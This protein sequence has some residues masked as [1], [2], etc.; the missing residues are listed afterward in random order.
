MQWAA[1][2][3]QAAE[4][5]GFTACKLELALMPAAITVLHRMLIGHEDNSLECFLF[6]MSVLMVP[7]ILGSWGY[8]FVIN[9][10]TI[11][12]LILDLV[13]LCRCYWRIQEYPIKATYL[14]HDDTLAHLEGIIEETATGN[15]LEDMLKNNDDPGL[16]A[17]SM[18]L[19]IPM[20]RDDGVEV[21]TLARLR[22]RLLGVYV[23]GDATCITGT[24]L[25]GGAMPADE[26]DEAPSAILSP[27]VSLEMS[28]YYQ[29][30]LDPSLIATAFNS[31]DEDAFRE[32]IDVLAREMFPQYDLDHSGTLN[33]NIELEQL[34]VAI[35]YKFTT[36]FASYPTYPG[37]RFLS[38][39]E[40]AAVLAEME[41]LND[42]NAFSVDEFAEWY[43]NAMVPAVAIKHD[44]PLGRL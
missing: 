12:I 24:W 22:G 1:S 17:M 42:E 11:L 30:A 29:D 31:D 33:S 27:G 16:I 14:V 21:S 6:S 7:I 4:L 41:P 23:P 37:A 8:S 35:E 25:N 20:D 40:T 2:N 43:Q 3:L 38:R 19:G 36:R 39:G 34:A 9:P 15:K 44:A 26:S 13:I 28:A 10:S 5:L 32:R 18:C